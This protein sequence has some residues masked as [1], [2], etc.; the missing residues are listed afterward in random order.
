MRN[1]AEYHVGS[2]SRLEADSTWLYR[3]AG[4]QDR[5]R[6]AH[7]QESFRTL[8]TWWLR[9]GA[10]AATKKGLSSSAEQG[11]GLLPGGG[12]RGWVTCSRVPGVQLPAA[13][14][15]EGSSSVSAGTEASEKTPACLTTRLTVR[16]SQH[17]CPCLLV[18]G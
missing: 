12:G 7:R 9:A 6:G 13:C 15:A 18:S 2:R 4:L 11:C 8:N 3:D 10:A 17:L 1:T 14:S 16:M 5:D